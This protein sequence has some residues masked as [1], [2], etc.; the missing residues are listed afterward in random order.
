[1]FVGLLATSYTISPYFALAQQLSVPRPGGIGIA[2][3]TLGGL[4]SLL[5]Q[6]AIIIA[7][8]AFVVLLILGGFQ[9]LTS[10]GNQ[11][12]AQRANRTMI[13]ALI[14]LGIVVASYAVAR[15]V[16][17]TLLQIQGVF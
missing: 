7:G 6:Y 3:N 9:Y 13:N 4:V 14:G 12:A 10:A 1:M 11:D 2:S 17:G 5:I 8:I 15:Y 16:V